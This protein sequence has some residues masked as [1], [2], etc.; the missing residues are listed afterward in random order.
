M[1][2]L[3]VLAAA[4]DKSTRLA[5][6]AVV[7]LALA[8]DVGVAEAQQLQAVVVLAAEPVARQLVAL[9][10]MALKPA[11]HRRTVRLSTALR[12]HKP[13]RDAFGYRM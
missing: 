13:F 1:V 7:L 8:V 5:R 10:P 12:Q 6:P 3:V 2:L 4:A 9:P 11:V